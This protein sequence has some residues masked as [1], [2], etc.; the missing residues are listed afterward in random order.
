MK[1]HFTNSQLTEKRF[2][3]KRM[4]ENNKFQNPGGIISF[5]TAL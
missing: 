3:S 5:A 2:S 1:I 4:V